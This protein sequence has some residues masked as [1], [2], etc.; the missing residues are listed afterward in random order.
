MDIQIIVLSK[1]YIASVRRHHCVPYLDLFALEHPFAQTLAGLTH[2]IDDKPV[3]D[4]RTTEDLLCVLFLQTVPG[5]L[6]VVLLYVQNTILLLRTQC[7]CVI[8]AI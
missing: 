6:R 5:T 2:R 3:C 4:L 8:F 1:R 7:L